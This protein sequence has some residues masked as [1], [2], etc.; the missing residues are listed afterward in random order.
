VTYIH[1][2]PKSRRGDL[3]KP[4]L[5]HTPPAR[6]LAERR[7]FAL[8]GTW[9]AIT[10]LVLASGC[11]R[12]ERFELSADKTPLGM[13]CQFTNLLATGSPPNQ[14]AA[15]RAL[16]AFTSEAWDPASQ[17]IAVTALLQ[18]SGHPDTNLQRIATVALSGVNPAWLPSWSEAVLSS[19]ASAALASTNTLSRCTAAGLLLKFNPRNQVALTNFLALIENA[20]PEALQAAGFI[21]G[22]SWAWIFPS[23]GP[24]PDDLPE[25][26][27]R[28]E[29][30]ANS[31]KPELWRAAATLLTKLARRTSTLGGA[32]I[33]AE[34]AIAQLLKSEDP[35]ERRRGAKLALDLGS[36]KTE[37]LKEAVAGRQQ[38]ADL[39]V[40]V[41][42]AFLA[43]ASDPNSYSGQPRPP[44][45]GT[46]E[47][48][49]R[50]LQDPDPQVRRL[51]LEPMTTFRFWI[52]LAQTEMTDPLGRKSTSSVQ[53]SADPIVLGPLTKALADPDLDARLS[54]ARAV[55]ILRGLGRQ[56]SKELW[57][58][59]CA[60]LA[61]GVPDLQQ[62]ALWLSSGI[63]RSM[64]GYE[65]E[66]PKKFADLYHAALSSTNDAVRR[67]ALNHAGYLPSRKHCRGT[68]EEWVSRC[69]DPD[70]R[71]RRDAAEMLAIMA[72]EQG[73]GTNPPWTGLPKALPQLIHDPFPEVATMGLFAMFQAAAATNPTPVT[74]AARQELSRLATGTD[75]YLQVRLARLVQ[76][77]IWSF[78]PFYRSTNPEEAGRLLNTLAAANEPIVRRQAVVSLNLLNLPL[79]PNLDQDPDPEVR[80]ALASPRPPRP[81]PG[82]LATRQP[83]LDLD[84]LLQKLES[85]DRTERGKAALAVANAPNDLLKPSLQKPAFAAFI[86]NFT[87]YSGPE[88]IQLK[89]AFEFIYYGTEHRAEQKLLWDAAIGAALQ[90]VPSKRVAVWALL[91]DN[92]RSAPAPDPADWTRVAHLSVLFARDKT[93]E[94][95]VSALQTLPSVI[96]AL[97][98]VGTTNALLLQARQALVEALNDPEPSV[99]ITA[100]N[101][102]PTDK[103]SWQQLLSP[104]KLRTQ[105]LQNLEKRLQDPLFP[106]RNAA[107]CALAA[108]A[109]AVSDE[110]RAENGL[111]CIEALLSRPGPARQPASGTIDSSQVPAGVHTPSGT[112]VANRLAFANES[113][114]VRA[115]ALRILTRLVRTAGENPAQAANILQNI[116]VFRPAKATAQELEPLRTELQKVLDEPNPEAATQVRRLLVDLLPATGT[117]VAKT[118]SDLRSSKPAE[119]Q[120]ALAAMISNLLNQPDNV[121]LANARQAAVEVANDPDPGVRMLALRLLGQ[122]FRS[123]EARNAAEQSAQ[124]LVN[125]LSDPNTD[126]QDTA[127]RLLAESLEFLPPATADKIAPVLLNRLTGSPEFSSGYFGFRARDLAARV[128]N[129]ELRQRILLD[130]RE[131]VNRADDDNTRADW[132]R[133][134]G[135]IH[136]GFNQP[137]EAADAFTKAAKIAPDHNSNP[138]PEREEA[139]RGAGRTKEA[140]QQP[141]SLNYF[142]LERRLNTLASEEKVEDLLKLANKALDHYEPIY[143]AGKRTDSRGWGEPDQVVRETARLLTQL[144]KLDALETFL[145]GALKRF[146]ESA[147]AWRA[148]A[149]LRV[150]Q[151]RNEDA[152]SLYEQEIIQRPWDD[153]SMSDFKD[154]AVRLK[155]QDRLEATL[156]AILATDPGAGQACQALVSLYLHS[157]QRTNEARQ[158]VA[159]FR[160]AISQ[161]GRSQPGGQTIL[162]H[163]CESLQ[164][165]DCAITALEAELA[166][167]THTTAYDLE[168]LA[169]LR[170]KAGRTNAW[171]TLQPIEP[172][173]EDTLLLQKVISEAQAGRLDE[174]INH[175]RELFQ[176]KLTVEEERRAWV[177]LFMT[178]AALPGPNPQTRG[179][180]ARIASLAEDILKSNPQN[181]SALKALIGHVSPDNHERVIELATRARKLAPEDESLASSLAE[182]LYG[183]GQFSESVA[184]LED[185]LE[186]VPATHD[187]ELLARRYLVCARMESLQ[188]LA[189]K[190]QTRNRS[191]TRFNEDLIDKTIAYLHLYLGHAEEARTRLWRLRMKYG[192]SDRD[193]VNLAR[194]CREAGKMDEAI[195][196]FRHGASGNSGFTSPKLELGEL[197][198]RKGM[199]NE[200]IEQLDADSA[201]LLDRIQ[202]GKADAATVNAMAVR[203]LH[204]RVRPAEAL[205]LARQAIDM[206]PDRA[207]YL[208][209]ALAW[210]LFRNGDYEG[211]LAKFVPV[212]DS[213]AERVRPAISLATSA[214]HALSEMAESSIPAELFLS[215]ANTISNN[216]YNKPFGIPRFNLLLSHFYEH[217]GNSNQAR[218]ARL[219]SG[220]PDERRWLFLGGFSNET[221]SGFAQPFMDETRTDIATNDAVVTCRGPVR[222]QQEF[223]GL[224]SG[225]VVL[226]DI[227]EHATWATTYA[228]LTIESDR[229]QEVSLVMQTSSRAKLWVNGVLQPQVPDPEVKSNQAKLRKGSNAILLK[230]C[231]GREPAAFLLRVVSPTGRQLEGLAL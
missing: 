74:V 105:A 202:S 39:R 17:S 147:E 185:L 177:N 7:I 102:L 90:D 120:A 76:D 93:P 94:L 161:P 55:S 44:A 136:M 38:D 3:T 64:S 33:A 194:L 52:T 214:W 65:P 220:F 5:R 107:A 63:D 15:A 166:R 113:P 144:S 13:V 9:V 137:N 8:T 217:Q 208:Q 25:L 133:V 168:R 40:G 70:S 96:R 117:P 218:A 88:L 156:R 188:Q 100:A 189:E 209:D 2:S 225:T 111:A 184:V 150:A 176:L 213:G 191:D 29:S 43:N 27:T 201:F 200:A 151:N 23:S 112:W 230:I 131:R 22:D 58:V 159:N 155:K 142:E 54:A 31:E 127:C 135:G 231:N 226:D 222:W 21:F 181:L 134:L 4:A 12:A 221:N 204:W 175:A 121:A 110:A 174:A 30:L 141:F 53:D 92:L 66:P 154:L 203:Y 36:V 182:A 178:F 162:S 227:L 160:A 80:R 165:W 118:Q 1:P 114:R 67:S 34:K 140:D 18:T 62:R 45:K 163:L 197:Y 187:S 124:P 186:R 103:D 6:C 125:A 158:V 32:R 179:Q 130:A 167:S 164:D 183:A 122:T 48:L 108:V 223:D 146:P 61:S 97:L 47:F 98:A 123:W 143:G 205:K 69:D 86:E 206:A 79:P 95:R 104:E 211:A 199:T 109:A 78:G 229:D 224:D 84:S 41:P 16:A 157:G 20:N 49:A 207:Y 195:E 139:L 59:A 170:Q 75:P 99:A 57:E 28:L 10:L 198:L 148:K 46:L 82:A 149:K 56:M 116:Q 152:L 72:S 42:M 101:A 145:T 138:N 77:P 73:R 132:L 210:A 169:R 83:P 85:K 180:T 89:K 50:G 173:G 128:R 14:R 19:A 172:G 115:A 216:L 24:K 26:Q 35:N 196:A 87:N 37:P 71:Q 190:L 126:V 193:W 129:P 192:F 215:S 119:R 228:F 212:L 106:T 81:E 11:K 153:Y 219:A 171:A 91:A 51:A 60:G 68:L